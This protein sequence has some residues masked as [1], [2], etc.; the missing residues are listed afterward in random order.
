M[1]R[2]A[3]ATAAGTRARCLSLIAACVAA[4]LCVAGASGEAG[5]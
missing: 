1:G 2:A 4:R 3:L 5:S